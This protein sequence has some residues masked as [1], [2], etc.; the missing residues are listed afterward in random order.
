MHWRMGEASVC[1]MRN[2]K[3]DTLRQE[4]K[5]RLF[6]CHYMEKVHWSITG[7]CNYRCR[8]CFMSA[9]TAK[10]GELDTGVILDIIDQMA[11][12]GITN[13]SF[14][15]VGWHD[16]LRGIEGAEKI[17]VDVP[18]YLEAGSPISLMLGGFLL[19][20]KGHIEVSPPPPSTQLQLATL[21]LMIPDT[22]R[23]SHL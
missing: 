13:I 8:H 11:D 3:R 15:G 1:A 4:Q 2:R 22:A 20:R 5:Y 10:Y 9:P 21:F 17:A 23:Q 18:K 14:E 6:P 16:W 7:K 19:V 12:C